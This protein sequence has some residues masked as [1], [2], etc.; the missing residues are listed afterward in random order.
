MQLDT[1]RH[2][3]IIPKINQ[4]ICKFIVDNQFITY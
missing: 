4:I 2:W 1:T 3:I